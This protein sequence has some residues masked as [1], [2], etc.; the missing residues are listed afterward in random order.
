MQRNFEPR[1]ISGIVEFLNEPM[2]PAEVLA[3]EIKQYSGKDTKSL[4]P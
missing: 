4:I 2:H 1:P 3:V